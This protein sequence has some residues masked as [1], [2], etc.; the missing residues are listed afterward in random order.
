V[1]QRIEHKKN[2]NWKEADQIRDILYDQ[3]VV[4]EDKSD[5]TCSI[6]KK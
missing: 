6:R 5:G 2:R 4:I 3:G 1:K